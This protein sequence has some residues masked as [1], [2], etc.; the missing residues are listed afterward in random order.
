MN[1]Y[2]YFVGHA[3]EDLIIK[4]VASTQQIADKSIYERL[5]QLNTNAKILRSPEFIIEERSWTVLDD[6][7]IVS[8]D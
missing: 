8:E 6:G 3:Y 4:I 1:L 2:T 7:D 5:E